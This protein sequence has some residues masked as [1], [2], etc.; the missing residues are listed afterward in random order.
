MNSRRSKPF[1]GK[2]K[3]EQLK[4]KKLRKGAQ[5]DPEEAVEGTAGSVVRDQAYPVPRTP[6]G[7]IK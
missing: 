3:K 4:L 6:K 5:R 7:R 1:S 2:Q